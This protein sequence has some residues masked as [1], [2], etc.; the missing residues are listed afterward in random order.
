MIK[1]IKFEADCVVN[2]ENVTI[3][4]GNISENSVT[5]LCSE[6]PY[7]DTCG[8]KIYVDQLS[9][10][11]VFDFQERDDPLSFISNPKKVTYGRIII[12][13]P[14]LLFCE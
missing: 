1:E 11:F 9:N 2:D 12:V 6:T 5:I 10:F 3:V 13:H 7:R 4:N 8:R 14:F